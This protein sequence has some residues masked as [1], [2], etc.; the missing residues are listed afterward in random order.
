MDKTFCRTCRPRGQGL[1]NVTTRMSTRPRMTSRTPHL[2]FNKLRSFEI[3][4]S[5]SI[6]PLIFRIE[7]SQLR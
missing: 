6:K 7:I 2:L 1:Q 5:L 3:R 4:K